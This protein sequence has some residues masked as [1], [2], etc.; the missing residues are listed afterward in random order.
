MSISS[1]ASRVE[2][3]VDELCVKTPGR[4]VGSPGN[5]RATEFFRHQ[6]AS[7]GF[8]TECP[9]FECIDWEHG[10]VT[11]Q[12]GG[13]RFEA[14]VSPYSLPCDVIAPLVC[15]STIEELEDAHI[16][17]NIAVLRS[18]LAREQLMPKNFPFY[19]PDDHQKIIGLLEQGE[20]AAIISATSRNPAMAGG[21]YPFPM[22]ED[23]DFDIPSVYLTEEEGHRLASHVGEDV[24]LKFES[25]RIPS[26]G[27]NVIARKGAAQ[28]AR[29]VFCA[30]IDAKKGTPGALDNAAGV[31]VL[32]ALAHILK[33][34][35]GRLGLE[36]VALNGE[37]YYAVPGQ[38]LYVSSNAGKLGEVLLGVNIDGAGYRDGRTAYSL[39]GCTDEIARAVQR[40]FGREYG[41]VEGEP[42]VQGDHMLFVMGQR[43]AVAITSERAADLLTSV[44]HTER[45]RPELLD[46]GKL[47][48][49]AE[50]LGSLFLDIGSSLS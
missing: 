18:E 48:R 28:S 9:E 35:S 16:T 15:A 17:G 2:S 1:L 43:P 44:I 38:L 11:L 14:F 21:L 39:C 25:S 5:R 34:Y 10:D 42:W 19:N 50:G 8:Q 31:A 30:H 3:Y 22:F 46:Y 41:F 40:N 37:D 47:A 12:V 7:F 32:L 29:V 20:P 24:L 45:D 26:R 27:C 13:A 36:I 33:D 6:V 23:G 4:Q 49:I